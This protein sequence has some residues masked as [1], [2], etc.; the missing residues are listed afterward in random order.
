MLKWGVGAT[1]LVT[2][3]LALATPAARATHTPVG[4]AVYPGDNRCSSSQSS[5]LRSAWQEAYEYTKHADTLIRYIAA[6]PDAQAR[7]LWS[8][9]FTGYGNLKSTNVND[10]KL[11]SSPQRY[12][13]NFDRGRLNRIRDTLTTARRRFEGKT[14]YTLAC[15]TVCPKASAHHIVRGRIVTCPRFWD[16]ARDPD[17]N[18]TQAT[19][20]SESADTL[21]HE[22]HHH[23]TMTVDGVKRFIEDYHT[24]GAGPLP[25]KKYYGISNVTYLAQKAPH[26]AMRNND[27]YAAF[28]TWA[29]L[30]WDQPPMF[31]GGWIPREGSGTGGLFVDLSWPQLIAKREELKGGQYLADVET[32]IRHGERRYSA[33]WRIGERDAGFYATAPAAFL[34]NWAGRKG[35][36][37]LI[38]I[39]RYLA[40]GQERLLGVYRAKA[41]G[42]A[43][44]GGLYVDQTWEQLVARHKQFAPSAY[45]ADVETYVKAGKR[46]FIG[47]WLV[48]KGAGALYRTT[49]LSTFHSLAGETHKTQVLL[50][51]ERYL[52]SDGGLNYLGVWRAPPDGSTPA[53]HSDF[54]W[55]RLPDLL[56]LFESRANSFTM[57]DLDESSNVAQQT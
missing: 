47:L 49:D 33:L 51:V 15:S 48:G 21:V 10:W 17:P 46:L 12:F 14:I 20:I 3:L 8:A 4:N 5:Y 50:D 1:A 25:N 28:A 39:E 23:I 16:R 45:L 52:G 42:A 57:V 7:V 41:P 27:T 19:R 22:V 26:W 43:G 2:M 35:T 31:T 34:Q 54:S 37:D 56:A 55:A 9:D 18:K 13:G 29:D 32:Y 6:Q 44:D 24:D 38:D 53:Y 30:A 40:G 36:Q 11:T